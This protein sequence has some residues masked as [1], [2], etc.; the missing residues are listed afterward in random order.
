MCRHA[1]ILVIGLF[2]ATLSPGIWAQEQPLQVTFTSGGDLIHAV[3]FRGA[4]D[5]PHPTA[6]LLH[7]F[8]GGDADVMGTGAAISRDGWNA[9]AFNYRGMFRN[10]GLHTPL[11]TAADGPAALDYL[12]SA[13]LEFIAEGQWVMVG[14]S[15]GG[16]VGL[17]TA[18]TDARVSCV[19][20]IG[21]GNMGV[22]AED[23][24]SSPDVR[25]FWEQRLEETMRGDPARGVG[26]KLT[27]EEILAN[28]DWFDIRNH[29]EALSQKPVLLIGGWRDRTAPLE[30]YTLPMSRAIEV[31]DGNNL[32]ALVFDDGHNFRNTRE[33]V[34]LAIRSWL[35]T[36]CRPALPG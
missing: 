36:G 27:V 21:P 15:Y 17:L 13:D 32:S 22:I 9:L 7:G 33:E 6:I 23:I 29:G 19:A 12:Q 20:G 24:R 4:G 28:S 30:K 14:H 10:E 11:N 3:L 25:A 18:A 35:S 16:W 5:G 31:V 2:L 34:R 1:A 26:G 8:P